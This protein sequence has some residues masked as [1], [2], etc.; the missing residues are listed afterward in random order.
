MELIELGG[1]IPT[2]V[3]TAVTFAGGVRSYRGLRTL[4]FGS[5]ACCTGAMGIEY[6]YNRSDD[7]GRGHTQ[8]V[9][10]E[11]IQHDPFAKFVCFTA[12]D[13]GDSFLPGH[14]AHE[15]GTG[16]RKNCAIG[17]KR[18]RAQKDSRNGRRGQI[19]RERG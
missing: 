19:G 12:H 17:V 15:R 16:A 10:H 11:S 7:I 9:S 2:S 13:D 18:M 1:M 5:E 14:H 3:T 4:R 8:L 6:Q